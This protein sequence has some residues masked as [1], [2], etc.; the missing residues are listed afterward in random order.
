MGEMVTVTG[1]NGARVEGYLT[2]PEGDGRR[3]AVV[4]IQ[5]WWGLVDHIKDVADRFAR[6]GFLAL[7]PDLYHGKST[8]EPDE[9][10]KLMMDMR[11][12]DAARDLDAVIDYLAAHPRSNG[13]VGT[14]GFCLG[15]GLSLMAACRNAKIGACVD[16]YGVLP[17]GQP[18]CDQLRAP[19][20]GIFGAADPWMPPDGVR[21][22]EESLRASGKQ[23]ETVIY[24]ERDHA[25]FNDTNDSGYHSADAADAWR[26]TIA[27]FNQH[28]R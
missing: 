5:E 22:L 11:R 1:S 17:A 20:L 6:E 28:L 19:V 9:A 8:A 18:D 7:A 4:V 13:K 21:A 15:G 14:I 3:P 27:F 12:E 10:N 23:I 2:A 26:R 25:F 24:P 16:F